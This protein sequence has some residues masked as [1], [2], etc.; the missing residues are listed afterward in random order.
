ME[1]IS[2]FKMPFIENIPEDADADADPGTL[3]NVTR[4]FPGGDDGG[5]EG[6]REERVAE[7]SGGS[8]FVMAMTS[9]VI[10]ICASVASV[11]VLIIGAIVAWCKWRRAD[12][13]GAMGAWQRAL[14][15][16]FRLAAFAQPRR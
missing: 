3:L 7:A 6:A 2:R 9:D 16:A 8:P 12:E 10:S 14:L 1:K 15:V 13:G 5:G 4:A 11:I